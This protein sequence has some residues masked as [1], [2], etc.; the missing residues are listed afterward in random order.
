[1]KFV[2]F[3]GISIVQL[4]LIFYSLG[5]ITE[6]RKH[7]LSQKVLLFVTLGV[8]FDITSTVCM[9]IGSSQG[10][11][12]VHGIIGYTGLL[13]MLIDCILLWKYYFKFGSSVKTNHTLHLY[14]RIAY[15]C[16][17][18]AYITGFILVAMRHSA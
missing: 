18:A 8:I 1:M 11:F 2:L 16:W 10:A 15:I 13:L 12:T 9:I 4:A 6:Q 17:I 7:Y 3:L 14:S 5:I